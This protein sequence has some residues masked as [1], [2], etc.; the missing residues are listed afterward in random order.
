MIAIQTRYLPWTH[1]QPAR[2]QA[3]TVNGHRLMLPAY[4]SE[5]DECRNEDEKHAKIASMLAQQ[6]GWYRPSN[7]LLGGTT[8]TGMCFVFSDSLIAPK[9]GPIS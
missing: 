4:S 6:Q 8:C 9:E 1:T 3:Y 5:F 7:Y 2:F